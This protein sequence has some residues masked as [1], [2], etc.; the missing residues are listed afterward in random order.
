MTDHVRKQIRAAA[1]TALTNLT[2]TSGRVYEGRAHS[3][4][5]ESASLLVDVGG[6]R[7]ESASAFGAARVM[8]RELELEVRGVVKGTGYLATLD[9][10]V[11][12]VENAFAADQSLGGL[13]KW[14]QP[15]EY[16]RPEIEG[17][18]EKTVAV[19]TMRFNVTY[20]AALNA[21]TQ[22]L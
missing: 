6:E 17:S 16:E 21:P 11:L 10:I 9:A 19:Q 14:V 12:E 20:F 15:A 7:I 1:V 18:G 13:A 4:P 22:A 3:L 8:Q 5:S 2:T